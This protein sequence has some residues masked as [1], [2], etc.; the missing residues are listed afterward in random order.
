MGPKTKR[1]SKHNRR[2]EAS[3][4]DA[5]NSLSGTITV[6]ESGEFM[7]IKSIEPITVSVPY[8]HRET[9]SRLARDGVTAVLVKITT[10]DGI[11]GWGESCPGPNVESVY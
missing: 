3:P 6:V 10:D 2:R 4:E 5:Q 1:G 8:R 7:K 11:V 9:S